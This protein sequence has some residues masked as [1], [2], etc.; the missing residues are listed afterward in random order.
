MLDLICRSEGINDKILLPPG[1][2]TPKK[3]FDDFQSDVSV[4]FVVILE[5]VLI[6]IQ[7]ICR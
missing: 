3:V 1:G 4:L 6:L 7:N 5:A 2:E